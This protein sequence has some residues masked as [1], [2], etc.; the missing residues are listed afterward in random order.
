MKKNEEQTTIT[1]AAFILFDTSRQGLKMLVET[2]EISEKE[3]E[4]AMRD[5]ET[6]TEMICIKGM[7]TVIDSLLHILMMH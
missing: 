4:I 6:E 3:I 2:R 7:F 1:E 5:L